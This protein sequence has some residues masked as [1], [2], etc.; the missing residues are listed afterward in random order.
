MLRHTHTSR[1]NIGARFQLG[2][3]S[4]APGAQEALDI[5]GEIAIQFLRRHMS[6]GWREISEDDAQENEFHSEKG[7]RLLCVLNGKRTNDLDHH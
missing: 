1:P 6:A 4:I 2:E 3:R 7:F 5:A